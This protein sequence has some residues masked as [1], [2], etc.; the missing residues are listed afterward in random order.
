VGITV[1]CLIE[2]EAWQVSNLEI[3]HLFLH[4]PIRETGV[5]DFHEGV[6][7][8]QPGVVDFHVGVVGVQRESSPGQKSCTLHRKILR[9]AGRTA[10]SK[11]RA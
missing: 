9:A 1:C 6:V 8:L 10:D 11:I 2:A 3:E 4:L 7:D 5:V